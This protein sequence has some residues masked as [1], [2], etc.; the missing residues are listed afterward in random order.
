MR[1]ESETICICG[2]TRYQIVGQKDGLDVAECKEC[3]MLRVPF[4][5]TQDYAAMYQNGGYQTEHVDTSVGLPNAQ[6][7][8]HDHDIA[9]LRLAQL[10]RFKASGRLLD[11][12]C[13]N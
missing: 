5:D 4:L 8:A 10:N 7:Y 2:E 9:L 3:G 6:R 13:S 12:G 11:L 1:T